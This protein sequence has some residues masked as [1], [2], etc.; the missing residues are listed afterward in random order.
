MRIN[1]RSYWID[2]DIL[3]IIKRNFE[4]KILLIGWNVTS[5]KKKDIV[6]STFNTWGK[7]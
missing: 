7:I 5:F 4:D 3:K 1:L 6:N 2:D